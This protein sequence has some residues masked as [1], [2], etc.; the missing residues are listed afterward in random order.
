MIEEE[1][2]PKDSSKKLGLRA[3][4]WTVSMIEAFCSSAP[5]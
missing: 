1:A 4:K 5:K 2:A 3:S